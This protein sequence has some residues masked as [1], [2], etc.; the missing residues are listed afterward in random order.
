MVRSLRQKIKGNNGRLSARVAASS[1]ATSSAISSVSGGGTNVRSS[2][3]PSEGY[4]QYTNLAVKRDAATD[5]KN[6]AAAEAAKPK[7]YAPPS[8]VVIIDQRGRKKTVKYGSAGHLQ[9]QQNPYTAP[10]R[11]VVDPYN[12][13]RGWSGFGFGF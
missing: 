8:S 10:T 2:L 6:A 9:F 13:L 4:S 11:T 1:S 3:S 12:Q 5:A 7:P